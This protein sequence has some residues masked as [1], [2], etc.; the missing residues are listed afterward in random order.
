MKTMHLD[1]ETKT[2]NRQKVKPLKGIITGH[3]DALPERSN[4]T[5]PGCC[6]F[7]PKPASSSF[8]CLYLARKPFL[9]FPPAK[10]AH[11]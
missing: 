7:L 8:H 1:R 11:H 5:D 2:E 4:A 9:S 6:S 10:V 3:K